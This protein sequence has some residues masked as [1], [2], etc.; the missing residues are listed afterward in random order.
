MF[1]LARVECTSLIVSRQPGGRIGVSL[2]VPRTTITNYY[3]DYQ[4]KN[5]DIVAWCF[6]Q[7]SLPAGL[8]N[9][10]KTEVGVTLGPRR[11][12]SGPISALGGFETA[13]EGSGRPQDGSAS[14]SAGF[15]SAARAFRE[16]P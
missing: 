12:C 2:E 11:R 4:F 15:K 13:Q 10:V 9:F 3:C 8:E 5:C 1:T 6:G 14:A 16:V 7:T